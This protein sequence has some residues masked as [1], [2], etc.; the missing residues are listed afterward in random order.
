VTPP[1]PPDYFGHDGIYQKLR[2]RGAAGWA[3]EGD[4]AYIEM[5]TFLAPVLPAPHADSVPRL[6]EIGCGA[7]N[8]SVLL[9]DKGFSV[10]GVDIS[11]TAVA[12]AN[13]RAAA[14]NLQADFRVDNVVHLASLN[15]DSFDVVVD[16]HCLH[17]IIGEDRA[18]CLQSVL[19]VLKPGGVFLVLTMSGEV[20][21]PK[22][23]ATFDPITK[24]T[25]Y[26]GR[27]TR[28]VGSV[29]GIVAE[30]AQAGFVV[31]YV[32]VIARKDADDLDNLVICA[33]KPSPELL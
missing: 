12:W 9:A 20:L 32:N 5:H 14:L 3:D 10:T 25:L 27:P 6:L 19:R 7:G 23:L 18:R 29:D 26:Q 11:P 13:D 22:M 2:A 17:C 8:F 31:E 1:L 30:V 24:V 28:F 4:D 21:G 16:G 15:D 33:R